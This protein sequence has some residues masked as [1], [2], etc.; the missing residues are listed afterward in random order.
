MATSDTAGS[1]IGAGPLQ[2]YLTSR[3]EFQA[4]RPAV[5]W[6]SSGQAVAHSLTSALDEGLA[7]LLAGAGAGHS[8]ALVALGGYGRGELCLASDVDLLIVYDGPV[9]TTLA[10][11]ILYPLWDAKLSVGHAV[12]NEREIVKS[13]RESLESLTS[14]LTGRFIGGDRGLWDAAEASLD[15]VVKKNRGQLIAALVDGEL[16]VRESEPY[17]LLDPDLKTGRGG[18]RTLHRLDWIHRMSGPSTG[19]PDRAEKAR[20]ALLAARNGVHAWAGRADDGFH[21]DAARGAARWLG[22]PIPELTEEILTS[23]RIAEVEFDR[24]A[25]TIGATRTPRPRRNRR[26]G[27][28]TGSALAPVRKALDQGRPLGPDSVS[29]LR[30]D[31]AQWTAADRGI[32]VEWATSGTLGRQVAGQLWGAGWLEREIP[33]LARTVGLADPAPFHAHP[34][35]THLWRTVDELLFLTGPTSPEPW[36]I[37]LANELGSMDD[38][39]IAC[40][41]HD[42]GKGTGEDHSVAGARMARGF[43]ARIGWPSA[44]AHV[45]QRAIELHLLLPQVATQ[46]DLRDTG[47]ISDVARTVGDP[48]L[49]RALALLTAADS[50]ATGPSTW[51]PW[52]STLVRNLTDR[53]LSLLVGEDLIRGDIDD[54][55]LALE[56]QY[57]PAQISAHA[58]SMGEGYLNRFDPDEVGLHIEIVMPPL[59]RQE[60]RFDVAAIGEISRCVVAAADQRGFLVAVAGVFALHGIEV[61]DARLGSSSAGVVVDTFHVEDGRQG[62]PV[63]AQQWSKVEDSLRKVLNGHVDLETELAARRHTYRH[64]YGAGIRPQVQSSRVGSAPALEVVASD[65]IGLLHDI[66]KV[67]FDAGH[68]IVLAKID[69]RGGIATDVFYLDDAPGHQDLDATVAALMKTLQARI[70]L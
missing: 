49:L 39:V 51:S 9:P 8:V 40:L 60:V 20:L 50:R 24:S 48:Q 2:P 34:I 16:A 15:R 52:K 44:A 61:L 19:L 23:V 25:A 29:V 56:G 13:A 27:G 36:C 18:L 54:V 58:E 47:V 38:L 42:V 43:L 69:T 64:R 17:H 53:V 33:E 32:L 7:G 68:D 35:D 65:R 67:I 3:S 55:A 22:I 45:V 66:A 26:R 31:R 57:S 70:S 14:M 63:S 46:R 30:I 37:D 28:S 11:E 59:A 6:R 10:Q 41:F 1:N 5:A 12:R 62:G 21:A 4:N